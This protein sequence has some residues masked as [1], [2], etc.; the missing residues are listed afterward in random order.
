MTWFSK[1]FSGPANKTTENYTIRLGKTVRADKVFEAWTSG[2]LIAMLEA[3]ELKTNP[4]D[5]HHLLL[6][7][8]KETYR[9][10]KEKNYRELCMK[11]ADKHLKEFPD[12]YPFLKKE[13][14]DFMPS[15][16]TF[17]KYATILTDFSTL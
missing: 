10:R 2:N 7:I 12:I 16:P 11:Y 6:H 4:I 15:V 3:A 8:V 9:L 17:Q 14:K 13:F 1:I 5:R